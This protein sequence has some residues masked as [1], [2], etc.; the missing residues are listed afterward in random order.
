MTINHTFREHNKLADGLSKRALKL[1]I[2]TGH[3]SEIMD[4]QVIKDGHFSLFW[5]LFTFF[6]SGIVMSYF[7]IIIDYFGRLSAS[8]HALLCMFIGHIDFPIHCWPELS[9]MMKKVCIIQT[10]FYFLIC[11]GGHTTQPYLMDAWVVWGLVFTFWHVTDCCIICLFDSFWISK[12]GIFS[13]EK[14]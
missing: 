8:G 9:G 14:K 3:F 5:W 13:S 10:L 11:A 2:G 1:G 7:S 12:D 4:G 6:S